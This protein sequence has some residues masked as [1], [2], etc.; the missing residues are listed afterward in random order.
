[1]WLTFLPQALL[2]QPKRV[3]KPGRGLVAQRFNHL[4]KGDWGQLITLWEKDKMASQEA[5]KFKRVRDKRKDLDNLDLKSR[6]AVNL[7]AHGQVSKAA[8]RINSFGVGDIADPVIMSQV[9]NKYPERGRSLPETV[10]WRKPIDNLKGVR[11]ALLN[12][13]RGKSPGTGGLRAEFL[14]I[15]AEM[16]TEQQMESFEDFGLRYLSGDLP[17]WFYEVWLSV[18]TVPLFKNEKLEAVRPIG[19]RNPVVREFH[20]AVVVQNK[21]A[22]VEFFEPEQVAMSMSGGGKLVFSIRMLAEDKPEFVVKLDMKNAFNEVSRAS[23]I[24]ALQE[25]ASLQHLAWHAAVTLAPSCG[26]E[27][28]GS[29]WGGSSEGTAQGDP[30]SAPYFNIA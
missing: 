7:I 30:L 10:C 4:V 3:G 22:L 14:I 16:M 13:E 8:N 11:E 23:I 19:I 9:R 20:K 27:T 18:M 25:E 12:L 6:Q 17:V 2:R 29:R 24:E 5:K 1:M 21:T 28:G 15:L 26:L